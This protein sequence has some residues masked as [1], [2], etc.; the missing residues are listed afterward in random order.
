MGKLYLFNVYTVLKISMCYQFVVLMWF[1]WGPNIYFISI[2]SNVV[3][4]VCYERTKIKICQKC[5]STFLILSASFL[6]TSWRK[7]PSTHY[8]PVQDEYRVSWVCMAGPNYLPM[9]KLRPG[10]ITYMTP[11]QRRITYSYYTT[12]SSVCHSDSLFNVS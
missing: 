1:T 4:W 3:G 12:P 7:F 5:F 8:R 2:W 6:Q 10:H 9:I 11:L